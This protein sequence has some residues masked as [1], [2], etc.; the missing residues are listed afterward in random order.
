MEVRA[1]FLVGFMASGKS[2]VGRELARRLGWEFVDLDAE[3]E[4]R[5]GRT[6]PEIFRDREEQGFRLIE[7]RALRKLTESLERDTVVALGVGHSHRPRIASGC[8]HGRQ[9]FWTLRPKSF[10][11]A[12]W[13]T[14]P[15]G[16]YEGIRQNLP[17]FMRPGG[18]STVRRQ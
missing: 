9:F 13:R 17:V 11:D 12:P 6:I 14:R 3:I 1:V 15:S 16:L 2:S 18:R 4:S 10:G 8:G 5:E 7:A